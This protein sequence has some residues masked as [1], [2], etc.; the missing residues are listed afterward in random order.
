[1]QNFQSKEG[2]KFLLVDDDKIFIMSLKRALRKMNIS[3]DHVTAADGGVA[4]NVLRDAHDKSGGAQPPFVVLLDVN[5]P[6]VDGWE[7]LEELEDEKELSPLGLFVFS[8]P[9]IE[10]RMSRRHGD[11]ISG[12]LCKDAPAAGLEQALSII[13]QPKPPS[14]QH[15][16]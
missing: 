4:L 11:Q 14:N 6:R 9:E 12:F 5:M 8:T 1:M 10:S 2:V 15:Y 3:N 7:F 13:H 16:T